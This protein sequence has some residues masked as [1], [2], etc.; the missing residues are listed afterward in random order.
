M[1]NSVYKPGKPSIAFQGEHGA[2]SEDAAI[3]LLGPALISRI[4]LKP[5]LTFAALFRSIADGQA[6]YILL[7]VENSLIG[8]VQ[9][10]NGLLQS[11][12]LVVAGEVTIPIRHHLIGCP[13]T[14]FE[15]IEVVES[16]PAALAQCKRFFATHPRITPIATDDTA[17][18]VS[19]IIKRGNRKHAAIA[20][21]RAAEIYG[22]AIIRSNIEDDP[23]NHTR[24][25]L[26]ARESNKPIPGGLTKSEPGAVATGSSLSN[27]SLSG[28]IHPVATA[29]GSDFVNPLRK[30][31]GI[32]EHKS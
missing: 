15:E 16:H 5:C 23:D 14:V 12:S 24:F 27:K 25:L 7:P 26:L 22:G 18:S 4:E 11:S 17:G 28:D 2:F 10:A 21:K 6:D 13:G 3:E 20:G 29:P 30:N 9:P 1:N 8:L 31:Q 19:L 32:E